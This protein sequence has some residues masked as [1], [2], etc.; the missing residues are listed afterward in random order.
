MTPWILITAGIAILSSAVSA[1]LFTA[2]ARKKVT[3]M[4]D[5]LEDNETNFRFREDKGMGEKIQPYTQQAKEN[6]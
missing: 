4:L 1:I 6:I 5:A 3:Y 2:R